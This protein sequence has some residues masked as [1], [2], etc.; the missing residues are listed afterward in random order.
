MA[1]IETV[2][3]VALLGAALALAAC[4]EAQPEPAGSPG[5]GAGAWTVSEQGYG[6]VRV[7]MTPAEA[8]RA[9]GKQLLPLNQGED[10]ACS[11]LFPDGDEDAEVA[12]MVTD[13]RIARVDI[14][15][16]GIATDAGAE[17]GDSEDSVMGLHPDAVVQPHKY[18]GPQDHYL[19]ISAPAGDAALVYETSDGIV[20]Y[21]RAGK[22]P[23]AEYVEGCS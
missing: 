21:I 12:F 3:R 4:T 11:Y 1:V 2:A 20:D 18:G 8:S 19:V 6:P 5:A 9:F 16:P 10:E 7:G 17:I 23:E 22:L 15:Q 14:D 13:G